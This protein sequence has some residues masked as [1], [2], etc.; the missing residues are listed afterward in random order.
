MRVMSSLFRVFGPSQLPLLVPIPFGTVGTICRRWRAGNS[1][2]RALASWVRR[3]PMVLRRQE[4]LSILLDESEQLVGCTL[5]TGLVAQFFER[6]ESLGAH[7]FLPAGR[8]ALQSFI[9]SF[10][11]SPFARSLMQ[12]LYGRVSVDGNEILPRQF[13]LI[14]SSVFKDVGLGIQVTYRAGNEHGRIA[15]VTSSLPARRLGPQFWRVLTARPLVDPEG[16]NALVREWSLQFAQPSPIIVD[17][18]RF[19]ARTLRVRP[20]PT[21]SVLTR[22]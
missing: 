7:G 12:P 16:I 19:S 5:G 18:N 9:G 17:G 10:V 8:I 2:W 20:G 22:N 3:E 15:L 21:W 14:V 6:Y 4:S 13:S 1:P 11:S